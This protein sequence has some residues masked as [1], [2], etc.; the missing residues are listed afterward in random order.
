MAR[1]DDVIKALE[2]LEN[3][4]DLIQAARSEIN[5]KNTEAKTLRDRSKIL[6]EALGVDMS[7]EDY[8]DQVAGVKSSLEAIKNSGGKPDEIGKKLSALEAQITKLTAENESN[9]KTAAE[10]TAKRVAAVRKQALVDALT[11]AGAVKPTELARLLE[12]RVKVGDDDKVIYLDGEAQID[13]ETGAAK[14]LEANP[15]FKANTGKPG[16]GSP[17]G[18]AGGAPDPEKMTMAE[19]AA[20]REKQLQG[21]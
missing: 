17:P 16:G 12:D 19:Y 3:G 7:A 8:E 20:Y 14:Y 18:G 5:R 13:V 2:G 4:V 11:K 10:A 1:W 6:A 9:K 21:G 15:E